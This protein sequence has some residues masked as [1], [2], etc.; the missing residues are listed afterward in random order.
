VSLV[1]QTSHKTVWALVSKKQKLRKEGECPNV[2]VGRVRGR[3]VASEKGK[4]FE[5]QVS[6]KNKKKDI[7]DQ[8]E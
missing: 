4:K 8:G 7:V 5:E 3:R 1:K 6:T 2:A